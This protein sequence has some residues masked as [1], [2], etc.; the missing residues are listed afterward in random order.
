MTVEDIQ[1]YLPIAVGESVTYREKEWYSV[2]TLEESGL[3]IVY[4]GTGMQQF[5]PP[6]HVFI[7]YKDVFFVCEQ[8]GTIVVETPNG[9]VELR[10]AYTEK[11]MMEGETS[12]EKPEM[13]LMDILAL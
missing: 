8:C 11:E 10:K 12:T 3:S 13:T 9:V 2:T 1:V 5:A 7:P 4:H 6:R